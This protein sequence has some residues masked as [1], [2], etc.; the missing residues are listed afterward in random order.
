MI[1]GVRVWSQRSWAFSAAFILVL[2]FIVYGIWA[3]FSF[4]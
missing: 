1:I 2:L 3:F 4:R